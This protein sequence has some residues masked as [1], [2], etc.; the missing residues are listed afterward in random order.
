[1]NNLNTVNYDI[2]EC[3]K[4]YMRDIKKYTSL[5][6]EEE[7]KLIKA[8]RDKNDIEARNKLITSNLKY[9]CKIANKYRNRGIPFSQLI[10]E[11]NDALIYAIDMFD[12]SKDVKLISYAKWWI[13]QYLHKLTENNIESL[14]D[15]LPNDYENQLIN[16]NADYSQEYNINYGQEFYNSYGYSNTAFI[17][18]TKTDEANDNKIFI[19]QLCKTLN[20]REI[21]IMNMRYGRSPYEKEFT[22]EEIGSKLK[23]TKERVRQILEKT[24]TKMRTQAMMMDCN[25]LSK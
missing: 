20:N 15:E 25:F 10:S 19:T 22:L 14:E 16:D 9:T 21:D 6:K 12:T 2:D 13:N 18:E 5:K 23:L 17:E 1:M 3:A 11:A 7:H 4:S 8:Y 24:K